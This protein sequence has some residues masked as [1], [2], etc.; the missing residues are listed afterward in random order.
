MRYRKYFGVIAVAATFIAAASTLSA[1]NNSNC[2]EGDAKGMRVRTALVTFDRG[3]EFWQ[4]DV[5]PQF[6]GLTPERTG[7]FPGHKGIS[8]RMGSLALSCT[9]RSIPAS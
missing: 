9:T 7:G 6:G 5:K 4:A 2:S 1:Q 8:Q 3:T